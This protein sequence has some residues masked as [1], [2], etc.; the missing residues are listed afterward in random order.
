M[1]DRYD[2]FGLVL[3]VALVAAWSACAGQPET[4]EA[5]PLPAP[6]AARGYSIDIERATV[7]NTDYRR[8]LFT[9]EHMQLV[10]MS[11]PPGEELGMER[12]PGL[13]QFIRF[14]AGTGR[15]IM[16]GEAYPVEDGSAIVIPGGVQHD[17]INT[18][19]VPLK[20]YTLYSPP[21]HPPGTVHRT[22]ADADAAERGF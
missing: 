2:R 1:R 4:D 10:L 14:E 21:E 12:H 11:I 5:A 18:G 6:A 22:K 17:I 9:G 19:D 15:V 8:V 3:T 7:A 16:S 13:D 20:L